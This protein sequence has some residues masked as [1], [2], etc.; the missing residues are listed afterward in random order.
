MAIMWQW[1]GVGVVVGVVMMCCRVAVTCEAVMWQ[2]S[3][4]V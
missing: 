1:F 3:A 4:M 2:S